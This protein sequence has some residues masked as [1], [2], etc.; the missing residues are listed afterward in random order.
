MRKFLNVCH[1][2]S[3]VLIFLC[4]AAAMALLFFRPEGLGF[5]PAVATAD[6]SFW[7]VFATTLG[8]A[9]VMF[10]ASDWAYRLLEDNDFLEV[11]SSSILKPVFA[12]HD[13][14]DRRFHKTSSDELDF[15]ASLRTI[16]DGKERVLQELAW[17]KK[18]NRQLHKKTVGHGVVSF[19]FFLLGLLFLLY[20]I[21]MFFAFGQ[22][23]ALPGSDILAY[24][25]VAAVVLTFIIIF[26]YTGYQKALRRLS[27]VL[28]I[29]E[30]CDAIYEQ[31]RTDIVR[32]QSLPAFT[33]A[34]AEPKPVGNEEKPAVKD[35]GPAAFAAAPEP[36]AEAKPEREAAP[37]PAA[38]PAPAPEK[39]RL[40]GRK[41]QEAPA[42][43]ISPEEVPASA[44]DASPAANA[45]A[46]AEAPA[47]EPSAAAVEMASP[48]EVPEADTAFAPFE[49]KES[50]FESLV[51]EEDA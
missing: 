41:K 3:R 28:S 1:I 16:A 18:N 23:L 27:T 4:V 31:E 20:P 42:P 48:A 26:D 22:I 24:V 5:G 35:E 50:P 32:P 13:L 19:I 44:S 49:K 12:Q 40:F 21:I 14:S 34:A 37:T 6:G 2:I 39:K 10:A 11:M 30:R 46:E 17:E 7:K 51:P 47:P 45:A 38:D 29:R 9:A 33:G 8:L 36:A 25:A 15:N 43:E